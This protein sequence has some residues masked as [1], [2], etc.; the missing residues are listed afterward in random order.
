MPTAFRQTLRRALRNPGFALIT[1]LTLALGLGANSAMMSVVST[2]LLEPLPYQNPDQ[3]VRVDHAAPGLELPQLDISEALFLFYRENARSFDGISLSRTRQ[4]TLTGLDRPQRLRAANFTPGTLAM[5]G[6]QP[7]LGRSFMPEEERAGAPGVALLSEELWRSQFGGTP[8]VLD[9][10]VEIDGELRQ[11]VGVLPKRFAYPEE[12]L[13]LW[14]PRTLEPT[15]A[16]LGNFDQQAVARLAPGVTLAAAQNELDQ[17]LDRL[18]ENFPEQA[19]APLLQD[20]DFQAKPR[21]LNDYVLGD[22]ATSL[23][24][25]LGT[26]VFVLLIACANVAN[27][28]LVRAEGRQ[29]ETA[30]RSALG[31]NRRDHLRGGLLESGLLVSLAASLGLG[32]S[33]FGLGVLRSWGPQDLPRL[34]QISLDTR[35][36]AFTLGLALLAT[37]CLGFIPLLFDR[38]H[39]LAISLKDGGRGTTGG[40]ERLHLRRV[41]VAG[42]VALALVLLVGATLMLRSFQNLN[43]V[44]PGFRIDDSLTFRMALPEGAYENDVEVADFWF[45]LQDRLNALPGVESTA[46]A[47]AIPLGHY[48]E[49]T[50]HALESQMDVDNPMPVVLA[51]KTITGDYTETLG[52]RLLE[53]RSLLRSDA[54]DR[55][56]AVLVNESVAR[57]YWPGEDAIGQRLHPG[58]AGLEDPWYTVVGVVADVRA[59][60]LDTEPEPTVYYP[61]LSKAENALFFRGMDVV[62]RSSLPQESLVEAI[63]TTVWDLD[64]NLPISNVRTIDQ[65]AAASRARH[66]FTLTLL[67]LASLLA[68]TLSVVG[69]YG[70]I[71][72]LVS[73]RTAEFGI[74]L[75]LGARGSQVASTV[76]RE[77]LVVAMVGAALG[78]LGAFGVTR[79]LEAL[80]FE[81]DPLDPLTFTVVP[82][83][84][85]TC[86]LFA[87]WMP[88]R[89]AAKVDPLVALRHD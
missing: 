48:V 77:G 47:S 69:T 18:S 5:L 38:A 37:F 51:F 82:L 16:R 26:V 58:A 4:V 55:S 21:T 72:Y 79:W 19:V 66:A 87:C 60:S 40:R 28:F 41:L 35:S 73:Q 25:L 27:L 42:Q 61:M 36:L 14:V 88:A 33:W 50:G 83:V 44:D 85:L 30:L 53:G 12:K 45:R 7:I 15:A 13:D 34:A 52:L 68:L 49:R 84:L 54:E 71:A 1:I 81:V 10:T 57:R 31:A 9:Q 64:A 29:R 78:L 24:L 76:L 43:T 3:L 32:L 6:V 86:A 62:V 56:G 11:V 8:D 80:L 2:V 22:V 46:L 65:L 20:A 74:R 17:F 75:A 63:R 89:R 59:Q 67:L 70:V 23:W 39:S